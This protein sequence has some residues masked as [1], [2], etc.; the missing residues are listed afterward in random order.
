MLSRRVGDLDGPSRRTMRKGTH[1]CL[2]CRQRKIRCVS[3]P[4]ARKCSG[5]SQK[6]LQ[7]TDQEFHQSISPS[8]VERKSTRDRVQELES[9]LDKV[10]R[11]QSRIN[12]DASSRKPEEK[13]VESS[14][15][16][17]IAEG[18]A[19]DVG[20]ITSRKRRKVDILASSDTDLFVSKTLDS[21][22]QPFFQLFESLDHSKGRDRNSSGN[23][24]GCQEDLSIA[25]ELA[26][27][28]LRAFR[29]QIPNS[30]EL[31][32]ILQ[33]GSSTMDLWRK[34]FS[35][36][37]GGPD[38]LSLE[39]LRNYIYTCV[40]SEDLADVAKLMLCLALHIQQLPSGLEAM[41]TNLPASLN[42]MQENYMT[43]AETLLSSDE[44]L[45]GTLSGLECMI[46]Q[47]EYYINAGNL[48]KVWSIVRRA[49]GLAQLLGLHHKPHAIV[50]SG[51]AIRRNAIWTELWQRER[52]I[53]LI[54]GLP[55][56][57]L[58]SQIPVSSPYDDTSDLERTKRFLLDLSIVMG[59]IVDRDQDPNGKTYSFTLKID[60]QL[61]ECQSIM[62]AQWWDFMPDP[63]TPTDEICDMFKAKLRFFTVQRLLHLPFLLKA[64]SDRKYEGSR[65]STLKSSREII[66]IYNVL[67]D[68]KRPV[69][70][71]CDMADF[72]VFTAAMTLVIDLLTRSRTQDSYDLHRE[73]CDWSL[74]LQ[75]AVELGRVSQSMRRCDVAALGARVL[76]DFSNLRDESGEGVSKVD[77]PFFGRVEIRRSGTR[78]DKHVLNTQPCAEKDHHS[79]NQDDAIGA[80]DGS[81]ETMVS[82]D[83][84][85]FPSATTPQPWQGADESWTNTTDLSLAD[86]WSW[87]PCDGDPN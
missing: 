71:M 34:A 80:F 1:S 85:L 5:C 76:D 58:D 10:L 83:S 72:Q 6:G 75:T 67:R 29:L 44:R 33:A 86:D 87:F 53:S 51:L 82:L 24:R 36:A 63:T 12:E 17:S 46:L 31:M 35:D 37:L 19:T 47:S 62:S 66:N 55:Y 59:H 78:H 50:G 48:R 64:S 2:E 18:S 28:V 77:I 38:D 49:V 7:C 57:T 39:R 54:L 61:D 14:G 84:Y 43:S 65:L 15:I 4:N 81:I 32:S 56:S 26:H 16:P 45:E 69:L 40:Y 52:G 21:S 11:S 22:D 20:N 27:R 74:V 41:H 79:Q 68:E 25:D 23:I 13:R 73:D 70:K 3:E 9:K 42:D 60:E 30:R 8:T